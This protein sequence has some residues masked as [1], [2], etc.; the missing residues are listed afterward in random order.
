M[1]KTLVLIVSLMVA[2]TGPALA[3]WEEGVAAFTSKNFDQAAQEFRALVENNPEG[4]RG[5]YMLGL[6]LEQLGRKEEALHHLRQAYDLN[7]NDLPIKLALGRSYKNVRRYNDVAEL[8]ASVNVSS[9]PAAQQAVFYQMRGE[10]RFKTNNLQGAVEDFKRLARLKPQDAQVQYLYGTTALALGRLDDGVA[11]LG[12]ASKLAPKDQEKMRTYANVL[13][14]KGRLS[15]DKTTKKTNYL[16]AAQLGAELVK[17][18]ATYENLILKCSAEL[19]AG[20]YTE[21]V[22]TGE[23]AAL[24]KADDWLPQFYV[25]QAYSSAKQYD[26]AVK[27]LKKAQELTTNPDDVR[28]IWNQLGFVY[29]KQRKFSQSIA[30]YQNAGNGGAVA[31]VTEN[32]KTERENKRIE[33][34]NTKIKEME[35]EARRL[36]AELKAIEEGGGGG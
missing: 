18:K 1:R 14:R 23:A 4:Y 32:E 15:R 9:L 28:Q 27:P 11:A 25:G 22:A 16:K 31:R 35:E 6:S 19:G 21:A 8:L 24:K 13:I 7:P 10:A 34:E 36:E 12:K 17:A 5:H 2:G 20:L 33:D 3:G 26:S 29:E 30:A